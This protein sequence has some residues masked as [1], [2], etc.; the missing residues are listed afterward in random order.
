MSSFTFFMFFAFMMI[1]IGEYV[2][3]ILFL[4]SL[5]IFIIGGTTLSAGVA[6]PNVPDFNGN[7]TTSRALRTTGMSVLLASSIFFLYCITDTIRQ[8]RRE[9]P[10]KGIHP[11]LFLLFATWPLLFVRGLYGVMSGFVPAFN[12]LKPNY[13]TATGMSDSSVISGYIMGTTMEWI[14]CSL[15]MATYFTSRNDPKTVDFEMHKREE[16]QSGDGTA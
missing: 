14:S 16:A 11:T 13:Y 8:S 6:G 12:Y 4:F 7:F 3:G 15:L 2:H 10:G 1:M 5:I 9:N